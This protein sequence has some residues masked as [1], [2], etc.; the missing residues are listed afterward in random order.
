MALGRIKGEIN[1]MKQTTLEYMES[2]LDAVWEPGSFLPGEVLDMMET[3]TL[4]QE[5]TAVHQYRR[6]QIG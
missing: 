2:F 3:V 6:R 1:S 5:Q 4:E